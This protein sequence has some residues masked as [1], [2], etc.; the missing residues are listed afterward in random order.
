M[1]AAGSGSTPSG[2]LTGSAAIDVI[3]ATAG[4]QWQTDLARTMNYVPNET[5]LAGV[6]ADEESTA[7]TAAGAARGR[8]T[9]SS[10]L[11][12]DVEADNPHQA[13]SECRPAGR[14]HARAAR[15]A[16]GRITEAVE[17]H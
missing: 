8:A 14:D 5:T 17:P 15:A 9:P 6:I 11:R 16:S 2:A 1:P 13:A 3:K 7:A 10:P 4:R 12:V